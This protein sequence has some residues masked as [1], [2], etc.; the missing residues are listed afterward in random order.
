M[1]VQDGQTVCH[2]QES[3][4]GVPEPDHEPRQRYRKQNDK[5]EI[6]CTEAPGGEGNGPEPEKTRNR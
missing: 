5:D 1:R 6:D 2:D 3:D 4:R